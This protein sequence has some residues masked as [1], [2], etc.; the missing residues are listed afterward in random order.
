MT[1]AVISDRL[2]A[3]HDGRMVANGSRISDSDAQ[4]NP[5]LIERGVLVKETPK[6]TRTH[7]KKSEPKAGDDAAAAPQKEESK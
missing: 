6:K 3:L 5:R 7:H 4:K 1:Y 2:E